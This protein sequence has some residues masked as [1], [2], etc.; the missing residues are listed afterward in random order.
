MSAKDLKKIF[1]I[2]LEPEESSDELEVKFGTKKIEGLSRVDFDNVIQ[3]LKS[4]GFTTDRPTG[5]YYLRIQNEFIDKKT[6]YRKISNIRTE[7]RSLNH[8][9]KYCSKNTFDIVSVPD[10]ITFTHKR[11]KFIESKR[12]DAVDFDDFNFRIALK[13]EISLTTD[14]LRIKS[15][16]QRWHT[17]QKIYR[18]IKRFTFTHPDFPLK[19]DCSIVKSSKKQKTHMVSAYTIQEANVF[20]NPEKYE[21]EIELDPVT[22]IDNKDVDQIIQKTKKVILFVLGGIQQTNYPISISEKK[23]ALKAYVSL[24]NSKPID[25]INPS[26]FIGPSSIS[27]EM[28]NIMPI[29]ANSKVANIRHPYT[30]TEKADGLRK[31]LMIGPTGKIY[32]F[33]TNMNVQFTGCISQNSSVFNSLLDGEHVLHN[34]DG[35]FI[36][37]FLAFDIYFNHEDDVRSLPLWDEEITKMRLGIM[38][39][40]IKNLDM[41][42]VTGKERAPLTIQSKKFYRSVGNA[43][44]DNCK[45]I[46][47]KIRDELFDYHTDGIIFTPVDKGVGS[48]K[49]DEKAANRKRTWKFSLKWKP[50]ELNTVDFLV[51]TKKTPTG[52]DII[53]N[54]FEDGEDMASTRQ[55][56]QFKTLVLRVGYDIRKHGFLNP[57]QDIIDE[58]Y[59]TRRQHK[60][61]QYKPMPFYPTNPSDPNAALANVMLHVDTFGNRYMLT[62]NREETFED[63]TII[64]FRYDSTQKK[65]WKWVPIRVRYDKTAEYRRGLKN[66]GNAFHVAESVWHSIHVPITEEMLKT[67]NDIPDELEDTNVYYKGRGR[68]SLTK[69]LRDFHNLFIKRK[70]ILGVSERGDT[71]IDLAVGKGGDMPK[72]IAAHLSFVFGIDISKDNIENRKDG[73]CARFLNY[74]T[75]FNSMPYGLFIEGD[76]GRNIRN[77]DAASTEQGKKILQAILGQGSKDKDNLGIGVYNHFGK[78]EQGFDIV[79]CQFA[80]HYFFENKVTL[81]NLLQNISENCKVGGYFIGTCYDGQTLFEALEDKKEGDHIA[82]YKNQ[83]KIWEIEKKYNSDEFEDNETSIGYRINVFQETINKVFGEYLV[84]FN[85]LSYLLENYGFNLITYEEARS[86]RLPNGSGLFR[87]LFTFM[88]QEIQEKRL[89]SADIGSASHMTTEEK[90]VSFYN[91]Y[92]VFKKNKQVDAD[93]ILKIMGDIPVSAS[94]GENLKKKSR[95]PIVKMKERI[96]IEKIV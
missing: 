5:M 21:I 40:V 14:D 42:S 94:A 70:L 49:I 68:K 52:Q 10:Y 61:Q 78:G 56:A 64:E 62:E 90:Q 23:K 51:T 72:W 50:P 20:N 60:S 18:F 2:Y 36:N 19:I 75:K 12:V 93:K 48:D 32:L 11:S 17:S 37:L 69:A 73:I 24:F 34:K 43:I 54:L 26:D 25:K 82:G 80:L 27:L 46:L 67:G 41:K 58:N 86:M 59:P 92:F 8:I 83:N 44:F 38:S 30:V 74:K 1:D 7:I 85:Y 91:R 65:Y 81:H 71:L 63:N 15:M 4:R 39:N 89:K 29:D 96:Y 76:S 66:Y 22:N 13:E 77:G 45:I 35:K 28:P 88:E 33:N 95:K 16:L 47:D 9:R 6:G 31:L 57:C 55:I 53:G 84:N 79:S 3:T 87:E